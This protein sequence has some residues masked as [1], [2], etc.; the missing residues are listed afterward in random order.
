MSE[1]RYMRVKH[2][3]E[4]GT[5]HIH[6][7]PPGSRWPFKEGH[8]PVE[9]DFRTVDALF[10]GI[11]EAEEYKE[12]FEATEIAVSSTDKEG[13]AEWCSQIGVKEADEK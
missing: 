9:D 11:Y 12:M 8:F 13:F 10:S 5:H 7:I 3:V 4:D 2:S 1:V 6:I